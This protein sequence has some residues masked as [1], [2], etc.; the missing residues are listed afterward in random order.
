[1]F[2]VYAMVKQDTIKLVLQGKS[3][4]LDDVALAFVNLRDLLEGIARD[5]NLEAAIRWEIAEI[6]KSSVALSARGIAA[7]GD[8]SIVPACVD[9]YDEVWTAAGLRQLHKYPRYIAEPAANILATIK[10]SVTGVKV[11]T[12]NASL[13]L[14]EEIPPVLGFVGTPPCLPAISQVRGTVQLISRTKRRSLRFTMTD[15]LTGRVV[16]CRVAENRESILRRA[17][18]R[19]VVVEGIVNRDPINGRPITIDEISSLKMI[20]KPKAGT[21]RQA[22]GAVKPNLNLMTSAQAVRKVRDA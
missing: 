20:R 5:L 6:K 3:I 8:E 19:D 11:E 18:G 2:G 10:R 12:A 22:I 4:T 1:M 21:W 7:N 15:A 13:Q 14:D 17:W 16:S 9:R